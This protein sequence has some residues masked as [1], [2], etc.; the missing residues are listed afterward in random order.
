MI[1]AY[2]FRKAQQFANDSVA[3]S[4]YST[5]SF[6]NLTNDENLHYYSKNFPR[7]INGLINKNIENTLNILTKYADR[8][9]YIYYASYAYEGNGLFMSDLYDNKVRS[10]SEYDMILDFYIISIKNMLYAY[11]ISNSSNMCGTLGRPLNATG[12]D[13]GYR[14]YT[15]AECNTLGGYFSNDT[16]ECVHKV[17]NTYSNFCSYLNYPPIPNTSPFTMSGGLILPKI[18]LNPPPK[19]TYTISGGRRK[20]TRKVKRV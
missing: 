17:Q 9:L 16:G 18:L 15:L 6:I 14:K 1:S 10:R 11:A 13:K 3:Q 2:N 12:D 20:K 19:P 7:I 5:P 4:K 8:I